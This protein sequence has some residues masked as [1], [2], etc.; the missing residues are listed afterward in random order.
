LR[1]PTGVPSTLQ[2]QPLIDEG[3]AALASLDPLVAQLAKNKDYKFGIYLKGSISTVVRLIDLA[4]NVNSKATPEQQKEVLEKY[5]APEHRPTLLDPNTRAAWLAERNQKLA[6]LEPVTRELEA[7]LTT[8]VAKI[9]DNVPAYVGKALAALPVFDADSVVSGAHEA[10]V[11]NTLEHFF[12][13]T[14]GAGALHLTKIQMSTERAFARK[15]DGLLRLRHDGD[16]KRV[17]FHEMG[18]FTEFALPELEAVAHAYIKSKRTSDVPEKL[19]VLEPSGKYRD[20]EVAFPGKVFSSYLLKHY[21]AGHTEVCSMGLEVFAEPHELA[22]RLRREPEL[23]YL[24]L[25]ML[26]QLQK[27]F[28]EAATPSS[29][30]SSSFA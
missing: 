9:E 30:S 14:G 10:S 3:R 19:S 26:L 13:L 11:R 29:P 5:V 21:A 12:R 17:L 23:V 1:V 20:D 24:A 2:L 16:E 18:L 8:I 4:F 15:D 22:N 28:V 25:G 27:P 6:E 7:K